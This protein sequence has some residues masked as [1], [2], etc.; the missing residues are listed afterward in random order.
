MGMGNML[1]LTSCAPLK[2]INGETLIGI[3]DIWNQ[4][5][6]IHTEQMS[7]ND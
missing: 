1:I 4:F 6:S 7:A 5:D 3:Y 2:K